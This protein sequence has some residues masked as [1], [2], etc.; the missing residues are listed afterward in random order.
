MAG[1]DQQDK[2]LYENPCLSSPTASITSVLDKARY[3][4]VEAAALRHS[5]LCVSMISDGFVTNPYDPCVFKNQGPDDA[6]ITVLMHVDDLF[7][8]SSGNDN[9]M[10]FEKC[11]RDKYIEIK[12][13]DGK[14]VDYI[15]IT[16][17][18][19]VTRQ[20]F[21]TMD[22]YE[23]SILSECGMWPLRV[24]LAASAL[25]D[26]R[27][28]PKATYEEVQ[29]EKKE[30][31][32]L[33]KGRVKDIGSTAGI[34]SYISRGTKGWCP[35]CVSTSSRYRYVYVMAVLSG[36]HVVRALWVCVAATC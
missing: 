1:G 3:G 35:G 36:A 7:I 10:K 28:A 34:H 27:D 8:T 23:R 26:M 14:V 17:Y 31:K 5:N 4:C 24:T 15:G 20:V 22:N 19:D 25:F 33:T 30:R 29:L 2:R 11:M 13:I 16:I 12:I 18:L 32:S 6:R 21:I 9:H